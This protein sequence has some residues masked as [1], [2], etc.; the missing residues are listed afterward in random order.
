[1]KKYLLTLALLPALALAE[2]GSGGVA[3]FLDQIMAFLKNLD[4]SSMMIVL[5]SVLEILF[6]FFKTDKPLSIAWLISSSLKK[7]SELATKLAELLDKVLPQR[8]K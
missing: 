1:M 8:T 2:D 7:I 3:G 6:R 4:N 5:A